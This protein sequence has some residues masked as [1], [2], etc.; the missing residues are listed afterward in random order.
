MLEWLGLGVSF[1]I[2]T[3]N[4]YTHSL[5]KQMRPDSRTVFLEMAFKKNVPTCS[6][7]VSMKFA[8][9]KHVVWMYLPHRHVPVICR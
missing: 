9:L 4:P 2:I 8:F 3:P 6:C 7:Y 5:I 1:A